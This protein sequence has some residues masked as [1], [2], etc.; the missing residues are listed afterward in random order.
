MI[1]NN[2]NIPKLRFS[3]FKEEWETKKMGEIFKINAGGDI[4]KK[5]VSFKKTDIFKYPI[6][7]NAKKSKGLYGYSDIYKIKENVVTIAGRGVYIGIAHARNHKFYPIVRLLILKALNNDNIYFFEYAIN[8]FN[9]FIE[10]TGVP[11]LTAPQ[12]SI[13]KITFPTLPEQK[14]IA[15]FLTAVDKKTEQLTRKKQLLEQYKKGIMQKIFS[16]QIRFK[17]KNGNSFPDWEEKKL[18]DI[19][20]YEQPTKYIVNS[21]DYN[22]TYKIPV[23]TAGKTF[24]LGYTNEDFGI[25]KNNLPVIIFDDF[26]TANKYVDFH[27]KTKS[28]AMKILKTKDKSVN[29]KF[30]YEIMQK[31]KYPVSE[32]KRYWISEY[33]TL[34][35]KY[36]NLSE[37][38]QIANFLSIIDKKI[39]HLDFQITKHQEFKKGLLQQMFV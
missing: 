5:H 27:F 18:K 37:Q 7:A 38:E 15:T 10:S 39:G 30:V 36:P 22:N 35:I 19:L 23:L 12:I 14:K 31:L 2:K 11:Q 34:K 17:D 9:I 28:S 21:T 16:Q 20:D 8:N 1:N 24:I 33:Q 26:T 3:E 6:Y 25:F 32:H 29:I 13:Y 4:L